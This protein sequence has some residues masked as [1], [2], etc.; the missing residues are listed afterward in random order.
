MKMPHAP[1]HLPLLPILLG[2]VIIV[3]LVA[4]VLGWQ[5]WESTADASDQ[6]LRDVKQRYALATDP[7]KDVEKATRQQAITALAGYLDD[8]VPCQGEWWY[9]WLADVLPAA[10]LAAERCLKNT[11]ITK[12]VA[13]QAS[14]LASYLEEEAKLQAVIAT[15]VIDG[16][17]NDWQTTAQ[18]SVAK[19]EK[20]LTTLKGST[21]FERVNEIADRQMKTISTMW[22]A[23]ADASKKQ[24]R[25]AYEAA[26]DGLDNAYGGIAAVT[27]VSDDTIA[28]LLEALILAGKKL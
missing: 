18:A 23:L 20:E 10:K 16:T 28:E 3:A 12:P 17:K 11:E 5:R 19:A 22:G 26:V 7:S 25:K 15:L 21:K 8:T 13:T 24:D 9:G 6:R 27:D 14:K 1:R 4:L 2:A